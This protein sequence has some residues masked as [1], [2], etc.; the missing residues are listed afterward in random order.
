M[1]KKNIIIFI[2]I[3][4]ILIIIFIKNNLNDTKE[5]NI[6]LENIVTNSEN[7]IYEENTQIDNSIKVHITG[8]IN[9]PGLIELTSG[10][11]I[12]DAIEKAGGI[13]SMADTSKVNL[14]YILSD[15][16]KIYIPSINDEEGV[17][18]IQN[19]SENVKI[20]IN[21]ATQEE[22]ETLNGIGESTAQ[23]II[24]YR[25]ENGKFASTEELKNVSGIGDNKYE[26]IK[27]DICVK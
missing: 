19:T 22:L 1:N 24:E 17:E 16:E 15:G 4:T 10:D 8:E 14:A 12:L 2:I 21:T 18:Y 25:K 11:R 13:T 27:D 9:N 6:S 23:S 3:G 20:N 7:I 5:Y 26:K